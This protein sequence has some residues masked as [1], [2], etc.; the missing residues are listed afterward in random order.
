M[1]ELG[2]PPPL[3]VIEDYVY[4]FAEAAERRVYESI[5]RYIDRRFAELETEKAGK[6]FVMTVYRRRASSSPYALEKSLGRRLNGLRRIVERKAYDYEVGEDE[7]V[8]T[9]DAADAGLGEETDKI[10]AAYPTDPKIAQ[11]ES[12]EVQKLLDDLRGLRGADSKIDKFYKVL[13]RVT[14]DGRA[15]LIF[16]EYTDTMDYVK[17]NLLSFYGEFLAC[18]SG[19]GG[20]LWDGTSWKKVKKDAITEKLQKLEIKVLVCTDAASEGLNLQAAGAVIN[21]D[22]PWN[23]AKVEQRI[24][25]I[26]RIG[27]ELTSIKVVNFFLKDSVDE[28]VYKVLR[29]RCG[30]FEHFVGAM[31]PVLSTARKMLVGQEPMNVGQLEAEV[32][33][34]QSDVLANEIYIS[35]EAFAGERLKPLLSREQLRSAVKWLSPDIGVKTVFNK[36]GEILKIKGHNLPTI[37]CS[38]DIKAL[39][40]DTSLLALT[41]LGEIPKKIFEYV[42]RPGENLPLVIGS[43]QEGSFRNSCMYWIGNGSLENIRSYDEAE[44]KIVEWGSRFPDSALWIKARAKAKERARRIVRQMARQADERERIGIKLQREAARM[45]LLKEL[46]R[47]L[48]CINDDV[49]ELNNIL[50]GQMSRDIASKQRLLKCLDKLNGY[51]KWPDSLKEELRD[52][53][54]TLKPNDRN[55]RLLGSQIDAALEDPRWAV[56]LAN[57]NHARN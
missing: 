44:K 41:P 34:V 47:Y 50:F 49:E 5:T 12:I 13:K 36:T 46:G 54:E 1:G 22:L 15:A 28:K 4:D 56:E 11:A 10:S 33:S 29:E 52:F 32:A 2:A 6:G 30:V 26:D 14:D 57:R 39:E 51:P 27:Q 20:Q 38:L 31:Q 19:D 53:L 25:R 7:K 45:R 17:D 40:S 3:R 37:K 21:Y 35:T 18:Y 8:D 43:H 16:T 48:I 23:P 42:S 24:G 55:A 9:R